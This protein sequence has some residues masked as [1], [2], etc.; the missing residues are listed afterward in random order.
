[1]A[2]ILHILLFGL[3]LIVPTTDSF[4]LGK[5]LS[6]IANNNS[7]KA[8]TT[9]T[10]LLSPKIIAAKNEL[11]ETLQGT[12]N[13]K[14]ASL[15]TQTRVLQLVGY[16]ESNAPVSP[17]L[18]TNP[19]ESNRID[20]TWF[21]QYTQPSEPEGIDLETLEQWVPKPSSSES[22]K[23]LDSRRAKSEG[24]VAFLGLVQVD[25]ADKTT[26]QTI[27]VE[28]K[29]FANAVEQDFGTIEVKGRF[30]LDSVPNRIVASFEQGSLT[31]N[32]GFVLDFSILFRLRA[33]LRNGQTAGG[34]LETTYLDEGLR[35][36]RGNRG[37]LFVLTREEGVVRA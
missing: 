15:E 33:F 18:L 26:T 9:T 5:I 19:S 35:I 7:N 32:N 13:G 8:A 22:T 27:G 10:T 34:W 14:E 21:L 17:T 23:S 24:S 4:G 11:V 1:L 37:S 25:T 2:G 29:L 20:G 30:E 12:Q 6:G 36:G 28:T 3:A 16:L 31:L